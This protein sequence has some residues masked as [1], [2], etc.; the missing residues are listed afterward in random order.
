MCSFIRIINSRLEICFGWSKLFYR[1]VISLSLN[2]MAFRASNSLELC[3]HFRWQLGNGWRYINLRDPIISGKP[4]HT[5][6]FAWL[7]DTINIVYII[8]ASCWHSICSQIAHKSAIFLIT[9]TSSRPIVINKIR[10]IQYKTNS[11][12]RFKLGVDET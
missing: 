11:G 2:H 7:D 9:R 3:A 12:N 5:Y 8:L 10:P 1:L 6:G 4:Y